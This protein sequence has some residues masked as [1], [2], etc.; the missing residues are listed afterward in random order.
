MN[1]IFW[2]REIP[3]ESLNDAETKLDEEIG[4][5]KSDVEELSFRYTL[6]SENMQSLHVAHKK[7]LGIMKGA[8]IETICAHR[9]IITDVLEN[10]YNLSGIVLGSENY[11]EPE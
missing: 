10:C 8:G 2:K 6:L 4:K 5:L 3:G 7:L 9:D 1:L 11:K